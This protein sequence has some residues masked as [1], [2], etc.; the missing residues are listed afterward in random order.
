MRELLA[1][2]SIIIVNWN[3]RELLR[4][5]LLA[6]TSSSDLF[7]PGAGYI[8]F[9]EQRYR[10]EIIVVDNAS[11]DGSADMIRSQFPWV[12]L[13]ANS[14]NLGFTAANNQ[15]LEQ[16][17]GRY[18]LLLNP[19]TRVAPDALRRLLDYAEAH[20]EVGVVGPQLRY[21]DGSIQSSRRRFP[22]LTTFLFESTVLQ[23]WWPRNP[24]LAHYYAEDLPLHQPVAVDWLVGACLLVRR[25]ALNQA[26]LLDTGFFMYSEELDLC[27]RIK[28]LGWQIHYLPDATVI[29]YEGKSSEQVVA[30]RHH[31]FYRSRLRYVHKY[32]G[33]AA[34]HLVRIATQAHFALLWTEEGAKAL[35]GT[36]MP[37]QTTKRAMRLE[38]MAI[39]RSMVSELASYSFAMPFKK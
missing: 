22:T 4:Y 38:R 27:R 34:A 9:D 3:V 1:D 12:K 2:L 23:R 13:I 33:K 24:A 26:G 32:H 11:R 10:G 21:G 28:E 5:C 17:S 19:D 29:H 37:S 35:V 30:A 8:L 14:D 36:V 18:V 39:Y 7:V 20:P 31:H 16:A 25:A 6:V 15:G